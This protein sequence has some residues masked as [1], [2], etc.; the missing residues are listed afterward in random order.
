[1]LY[2]RRRG[3]GRRDGCR[4]S[5][6]RS[7]DRRGDGCGGGLR[8]ETSALR[9]LSVPPP[10]AAAA[11]LRKRSRWQ[12]AGDDPQVLTAEEKLKQRDL[13]L[14]N[15]RQL[16]AAR[17]KKLEEMGREGKDEEPAK[18]RVFRVPAGVALEARPT[19]ALEAGGGPA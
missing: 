16:L 1:M 4:D 3:R 8:G 7:R 19:M 9:P 6:R 5:L 18:E 12:K 11:F 15:S 10:S 17:L 14:I 13:E 2:W